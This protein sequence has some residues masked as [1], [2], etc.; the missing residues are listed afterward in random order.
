MPGLEALERRGG[1]ADLA[2]VKAREAEK[3]VA[4]VQARFTCCAINRLRLCG[5]V[6]ALV[7]ALSLKLLAVT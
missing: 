4:T 1:R 3:P 7:T 5:C 6:L 2:A